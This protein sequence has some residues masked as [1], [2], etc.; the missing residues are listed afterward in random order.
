MS[1]SFGVK[2]YKRTKIT[3]SSYDA[4]NIDSLLLQKKLY[5]KEQVYPI[6]FLSDAAVVAVSQVPFV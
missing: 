4:S 2:D 3:R 6:L 1:Q 5:M